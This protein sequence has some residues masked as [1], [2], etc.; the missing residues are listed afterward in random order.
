MWAF[1]GVFCL[2]FVLGTFFG[3]LLIALVS[4]NRQKADK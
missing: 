1:I 4:A 3:V 2:G